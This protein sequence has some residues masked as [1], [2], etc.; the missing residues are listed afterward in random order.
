MERI[1]VVNAYGLSLDVYG[2]PEEPLFLAADVARAID[3][4]EGN[5]AHMLETVDENEKLIVTIVR[6]G[7]RRGMW[8]LTENGL[9]EVLMQSRKPIA[10]KFKSVVKRMLKDLRLK[11]GHT[12]GEWF[13]RFEG[14]EDLDSFNILREDFGLPPVTDEEAFG[15]EQKREYE[16]NLG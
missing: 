12:I 8:F 3:Y 5:T 11:G 13:G 2:T 15:A 4:S 7:Q 6:S 10:K 16:L 1:E 14:V 9:Y